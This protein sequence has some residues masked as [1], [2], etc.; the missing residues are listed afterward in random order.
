MQLVIIIII[1]IIIIIMFTE[2]IFAACGERFNHPKNSGNYM[3]T[4]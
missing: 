4:V 3:D 2:K 1:I